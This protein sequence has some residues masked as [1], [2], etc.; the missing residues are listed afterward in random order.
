MSVASLARMD[1]LP[2]DDIES[3]VY[4]LLKVLTQTFVP[5][6]DR[7]HRW[8]EI[9]GAY[10]WDDPGVGLD[11]LSALRF[12]LWSN[13]DVPQTTVHNTT[14][15]FRSVGDEG[16]AQLVNSLLSLPL[17]TDRRKLNSSN[18]DAV[19]ISL[20]N[21]VDQAVAAVRSVNV[22]SLLWSSAGEV[23]G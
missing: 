21:L 2:H 8:S 7:Q 16:R 20:Q 14:E 17:P 5:S 9:L 10:H 13:Y 22:S 18:Y 12:G 19:L 23:D 6:Q 11:T 15:M 4:V 1:P 3:A